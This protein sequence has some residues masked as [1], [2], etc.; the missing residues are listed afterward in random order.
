MTVRI[1]PLVA[2]CPDCRRPMNGSSCTTDY[3]LPL[4][5]HDGD[6][7]PCGDC[8]TPVGGL[9][10]AGCTSAFC[11]DCGDQIMF[12]EHVPWDEEP[13]AEYHFGR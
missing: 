11:R 13:P 8:A 3:A 1:E 10:H 5:R 6:D 12:C 9:H 7:A 4:E 2:I